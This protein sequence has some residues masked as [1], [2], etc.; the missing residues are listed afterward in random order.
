MIY[1]VFNNLP[2]LWAG[3]SRIVLDP[4]KVETFGHN[5][6]S[7]LANVWTPNHIIPGSWLA[8]KNSCTSWWA[9][10][11]GRGIGEGARSLFSQ[12]GLLLPCLPLWQVLRGERGLLPLP[13]G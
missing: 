8:Q 11:P 1:W 10:A 5:A 13:L 9:E 7:R 4:N 2:N 12:K 6:T 3:T